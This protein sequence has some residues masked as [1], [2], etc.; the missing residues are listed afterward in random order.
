MWKFKSGKDLVAVLG[1]CSGCPF[2]ITSQ[3]AD[4]ILCFDDRDCLISLGR[5]QNWLPDLNKILNQEKD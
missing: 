5:I 3:K 2:C 4:Y 1:E